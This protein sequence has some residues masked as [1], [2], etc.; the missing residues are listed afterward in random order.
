[1]YC[2]KCGAQV[3]ENTRFCPNC[4]MVINGEQQNVTETS[5][6]EGPMGNPAPTL[7]WG[8]LGI[9]FSLT[10]WFSIL[11]LI[12]SLVGI[13]KAK[14]FLDFTG[15]A[16][17]ARVNAGRRLSIAGIIISCIMIVS[18]IV[19]LIMMGMDAFYNIDIF[20]KLD[21]FKSISM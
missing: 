16:E 13:N 5:T 18:L 3:F 21:F 4:N 20:P 2:K 9:G 11:G 1:M 14:R 12:F 17:N 8:I 7:T 6:Y 19:A 10:F 15:G